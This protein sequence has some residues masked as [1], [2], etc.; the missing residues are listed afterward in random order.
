M[1]QSLQ[2]NRVTA[3]H[4][5]RIEEAARERNVSPDQLV[6]EFAIEA[7]DRREWSR[8]EAEVKVAGPRFSPPRPSPAVSSP[9][10]AS[11][12]FR[13]SGNS[14]PRSSP[15]LAV[16]P[17]PSTARVDLSRSDRLMHIPPFRTPAQRH[18]G[19]ARLANAEWLGLLS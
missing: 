7:L 5:D 19:S 17:I 14:S 9:T 15:I 8:T 4:W 16:S 2:N 18:S 3:D 6:V 13:K 11:T 12:K 10:D 1:A